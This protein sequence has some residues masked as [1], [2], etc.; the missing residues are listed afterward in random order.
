[1]STADERRQARRLNWVGGVAASFEHL[2]E[3]AADWDAKARDWDA[4]VG[5][6]GDA[7]RRQ[8][9]DP[10]LWRWLGNVAGRRVLDAGCGTGYLSRQ[11]ARAGAQVVG[12]D[13]APGMV[14]LARTKAAAQG[15]SIEH[16]V[17]SASSLVSV[18]DQSVDAVVSNYV[19]MDL[20]DLEGAARAIA[21]VL[22]PGG[23]AVLVFS[24]P[25]F[26]ASHGTVTDAASG[27]VRYDWP[28]AYYTPQKRADP[29]WEHFKDGFT[30]WH[31]PLSHY[32]RAFRAASLQI[33][34]IEEPTGDGDPRPFS[35]AFRLLRS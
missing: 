25:C 6:A 24:H 14:D 27:G 31:R 12:V 15:L 26:P 22:A 32:C 28:F 29:P 10:V 19:L 11:L 13:I 34:E 17:D 3:L 21:R 4:Q 5:E 9:S 2:E 7:N 8:N 23:V 20:P 30:W 1:V 16:R 35:I 33:D 18:A